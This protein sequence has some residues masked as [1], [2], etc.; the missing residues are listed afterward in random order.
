MTFTLEETNFAGMRK[1]FVLSKFVKM[2]LIFLELAQLLC[3]YL[4]R[5]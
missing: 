4:V 1:K 2:Y 5:I 3:Y